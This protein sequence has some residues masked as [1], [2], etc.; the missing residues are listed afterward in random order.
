MHVHH[1]LSHQW[2]AKKGRKGW[3]TCPLTEN[4]FVRIA[5]HPNYPNR[6]GDVP[7]VFS[8]LRQVR[9][10]PGHHFWAEDLSILEILLPDAIITHAQMT[11]RLFT[12]PVIDNKENLPRWISASRPMPFTAAARPL[13]F[14]S[15]SHH[16]L[17]ICAD[18]PVSNFLRNRQTFT[19]IVLVKPKR[20]ETRSI[21]PPGPT[22]RR[23]IQ[24][25]RSAEGSPI[26]DS[27]PVW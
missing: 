25:R 26:I 6:P 22:L 14:S 19:L 10:S 20:C 2:F 12:G 3:A 11:G 21:F 5:S 13:S 7:T 18:V 27:Y 23:G 16:P 17:I 15:D 9:K 24:V 4:G 8:I 1:E